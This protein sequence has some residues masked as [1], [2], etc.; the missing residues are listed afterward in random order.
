MYAVSEEYREA[1]HGKVQT[2]RLTGTA[3]NRPFTDA[4]ILKGSFSVT[5]QCS[6]SDAVEIGQVYIGELKATFMG[7]GIDRYQ[8]QM[9]EIRPSLGL[10][11]ADGTFEDVPLGVFEVAEAEWTASGIVIKAY[12]HMADF[13]RNYGGG[14]AKGEPYDLLTSACERCGVPLGMT[15][16]QVEALPNGAET[17]SV[18][19]TDN[20][21]TWR[22]FIGWLSQAMGCFATIDRTGALVFR[23]YTQEPV[24]TLDT[25]HRFSGASFSDYTTRYTGLSCVDLSLQKTMYYNVT[26]D[27]GL[28]YNLGSNPFLQRG[29]GDAAARRRAVLD[30]LLAVSY[31][32]F[33]VTAIG[34][35]A[36]DLGD[37]L[38]FTDG[39]ADGSLSCITKYVFT[40]NQKYEM[41]GAGEDPAYAS[42][43]SKSDKDISGLLSTVSETAIQ[44]YFFVSVVDVLVED[45]R[46][47]MVVDLDYTAREGASVVF[48]GEIKHRIT[49]TP[50]PEP[51]PEPQPDPEPEPQ[52]DPDPDPAPEESGGGESQSDG[53]SG[54][55][56]AGDTPGEGD[57]TGTDTPSDDSSG[58]DTPSGDDSGGEEESGEDEPVA[59]TVVIPKEATI[60][61]TYYVNGEEVTEYH[62]VDMET[63]GTHLLHLQ[64]FWDVP[65][66]TL[67]GDFQ[68]WIRMEGAKMDIVAGEARGYLMGQGLAAD[69]LE[70][71]LRYI[72][73]ATLPEKRDYIEGNY[74]DYTGLV[75]MALY[76]DGSTEDITALCE[77]EPYD[78][79]LLEDIGEIPC[80]ATYTDEDGNQ[81]RDG[82]SVTVAEK[83]PERIEITVPP[84]KTE[85]VAGEEFD[86]EGLV[87][88][89]FFNNETDEDVT[90]L[91]VI[92]PPAGTVAEESGEV[93]VR[94]SYTKAEVTKEAEF[95]I[96]VLTIERIEVVCL[97]YKTDYLR[98]EEIDYEGLMVVAYYDNGTEEDITDQCVLTPAEGSL[99][100]EEGIMPVTVDFTRGSVEK[101]TQ[102]NLNVLT[103]DHIEVT[104]YPE[105]THY[106]LGEALDY[107]G[108]VITAVY[109]NG[110]TE[111]V[112]E[113]CSFSPAAGSEAATEG[114]L[115][116]TVTF[117][118]GAVEKTTEFSLDVTTLESIDVIWPEDL[119]FTEDE[120]M[121]YPG[122]EVI[123]YYGDGTSETITE[124]FTFD[125][126]PGTTAEL[127]MDEVTVTYAPSSRSSASKSVE[128][129][130][131]PKPVKTVKAIQLMPTTFEESL[132]SIKTVMSIPNKMLQR[133]N[134]KKSSVFGNMSL[135]IVLCA[136]NCNYSGSGSV[137]FALMDITPWVNREKYIY[138]FTDPAPGVSQGVRIPSEYT[139]YREFYPHQ[140]FWENCSG[141]NFF[142][143]VANEGEIQEDEALTTP[144]ASDLCIGFG[145]DVYSYNPFSQSGKQPYQA[146]AANYMIVDVPDPNA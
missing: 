129:T 83:A 130:V 97:P 10:K 25:R 124:G 1:M 62:P 11:L 58:G 28:T 41:Q 88:T 115:P 35:P 102:F 18:Y 71:K 33:R 123:A 133:I 114:E 57:S 40:F 118:K 113:Y 107:T 128:I 139:M 30:A 67:D 98:G 77:M 141:N 72:Y 52:P 111:E 4:N 104:G 66:D 8:W 106:V 143:I 126:A 38:R 138:Q 132:A 90:E 125:P 92:E 7:M 3:G 81:Y 136:G 54:E 16:E 85:Y 14:N 78:Y 26:P 53:E 119:E 100:G 15:R 56:T 49:L 47:R 21:D 68:V 82:F 103:V 105:K 42:A 146:L 34:N 20:I 75:V 44:F 73:V 145:S 60:V 120:P 127:T 37:C 101:Q 108:V 2:F 43:K 31:V 65:E 142:Y 36:Y 50:E 61:V 22:D 112:T 32:P 69:D 48:H 51:E 96:T 46:G 134:S 122:V 144:W 55:S 64:Y 6:G 79:S 137:R 140:Y 131:K 87:V 93:T 116:V 27:N 89:A 45:G 135:N 9:L 17:L 91:C 95:T 24:D 76:Q 109:E 80:V 63:A 84:Y 12:D 59:P 99:T 94:V 39:L 70:K 23:R 86:Y 5:N 117:H 19:T 110:Q 74:M 13:D 121:A 29:A